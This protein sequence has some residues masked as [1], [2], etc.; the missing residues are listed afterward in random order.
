MRVC[1]RSAS[2]I[3]AGVALPMKRRPQTSSNNRRTTKR[4]GASRRIVEQGTVV[5]A[6]AGGVALRHLY[7]MPAQEVDDS[8]S[9]APQLGQPAF[10][11]ELVVVLFVD[12]DALGDAQLA[13][14]VPDIRALKRPVR[15]A[16]HG[17]PRC[18]RINSG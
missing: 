3:C 18:V 9:A 5:G 10:E 6:R 8:L 11:Q 13:Q 4:G 1:A 17:H 7:H 2:T 12:N 16:R 14:V 15:W